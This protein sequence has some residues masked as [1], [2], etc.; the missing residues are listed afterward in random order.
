M[1]TTFGQTTIFRSKIPKYATFMF[2]G[3]VTGKIFRRHYR[4]SGPSARQS[5]PVPIPRAS[6]LSEPSRRA[7]GSAVSPS[8]RPSAQV[9]DTCPP[10]M[11][12][13]IFRTWHQE[14]LKCLRSHWVCKK[15]T[16]WYFFLIF[17]MHHIDDIR[18]FLVKFHNF[19]SSFTISFEFYQNSTILA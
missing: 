3:K 7:L 19:L 5:S 12:S 4:R 8:I 2:A 11:L 9:L 15:K 1:T 16:T 10:T 14:T 17:C 13:V 18:D 6:Q